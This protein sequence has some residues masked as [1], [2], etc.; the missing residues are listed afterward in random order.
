[1]KSQIANTKRNPSLKRRGLLVTHDC[2]PI[3]G[4][5]ALLTLP[6]ETLIFHGQYQHA[7]MTVKEAREWSLA[8]LMKLQQRQ[9]WYFYK[10]ISQEQETKIHEQHGRR[11]Y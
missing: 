9:G 8:Q 5:R 10:P 2:K 7:P 3:G 6:E 1:M 11:E 4:V